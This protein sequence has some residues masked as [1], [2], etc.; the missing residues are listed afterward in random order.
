MLAL[1]MEKG[2]ASQGMW[3]P[4]EAGKGKQTDSFLELPEELSPADIL[5]LAHRDTYWA[6]DL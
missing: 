5:I 4:P 1:K 2:I 6:F 3:W